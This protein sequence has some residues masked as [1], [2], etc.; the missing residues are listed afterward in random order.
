MSF[1]PIIRVSANGRHFISH[2]GA[3]ML[4]LRT[5]TGTVAFVERG[6]KLFVKRDSDISSYRFVIK[7]REKA[8]SLCCAEL[9]R[10]IEKLTG[11]KVNPQLNFLVHRAVDGEHALEL[12]HEGVTQMPL[13]E[14]TRRTRR[15]TPD[16]VSLEKDRLASSLAVNPDITSSDTLCDLKMAVEALEV[17]ERAGDRSV[18]L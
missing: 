3:Q 12:I 5:G 4:G 8:Y 1:Y 9:V 15:H 18:L 7:G 11:E 17:A 14:R 2:L 16:L 13:P 10:D 6:G